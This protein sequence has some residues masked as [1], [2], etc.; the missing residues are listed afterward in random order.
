MIFLFVI[1][2][3]LYN[4]LYVRYAILIIS[5]I[6]LFIKKEYIIKLLRGYKDE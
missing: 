5:L 3:L 6:I 2:V 4:T 1:I